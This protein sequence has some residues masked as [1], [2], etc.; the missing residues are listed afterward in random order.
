M[1]SCASKKNA[2]K[3]AVSIISKDSMILILTDMHLADADAQLRRVTFDS[4]N[5]VLKKDFETIFGHYNINTNRFKQSLKYYTSHPKEM[6]EMYVQVVT[7]LSKLN[8]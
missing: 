6:D 2:E 5:V 1:I 3:P 8:N 7:N 4:S